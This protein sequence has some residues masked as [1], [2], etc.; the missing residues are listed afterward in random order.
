MSKGKVSPAEVI[1]SV[2]VDAG[3]LRLL[4]FRGILAV[5]ITDHYGS[6]AASQKNMGLK[7]LKVG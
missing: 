2:S 7:L 1:E 4:K 5:L 6:R 3:T